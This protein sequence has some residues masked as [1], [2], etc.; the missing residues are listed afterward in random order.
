MGMPE[1]HKLT[2]ISA[3]LQRS[4]FQGGALVTRRAHVGA[5]G[6]GASGDSPVVPE[7]LRVGAWRFCRG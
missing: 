3:C 6:K 5:S 2:P 4:R 1:L 7:R